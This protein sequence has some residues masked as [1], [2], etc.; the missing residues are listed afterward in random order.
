MPE[1]RPVPA[2]FLAPC[3]V[4]DV[5]LTTTGDLVTSRNRYKEAF[6]KCAAK[7]DAIRKHDAEAS[8]LSKP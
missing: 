5:Q 3:I 7:V 6:E 2:A 1:Y 8:R 4:H